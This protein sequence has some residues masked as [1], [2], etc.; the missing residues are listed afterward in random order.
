MIKP[1]LLI[2][3]SSKHALHSTVGCKPFQNLPW[4]VMGSRDYIKLPI[5]IFATICYANKTRPSARLVHH[6]RVSA[7]RWADRTSGVALTPRARTKLNLKFKVESLSRSSSPLWPDADA[8]EVSNH[9]LG[10]FTALDCRR[11]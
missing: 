10:T 9:H 2:K 6:T 8:R 4:A 1:T 7:R 5:L 11:L 3:S